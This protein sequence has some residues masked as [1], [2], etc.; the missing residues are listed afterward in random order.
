ML[1]V[2]DGI[3]ALAVD[4]K[5]CCSAVWALKSLIPIAFER[6]GV[7]DCLLFQASLTNH[8]WRKEVNN[9]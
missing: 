9:N 6:C 8:V 7:P 5:G 4:I 2:G 3:G 1:S